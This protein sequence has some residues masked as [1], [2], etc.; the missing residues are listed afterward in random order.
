M[1]ELGGGSQWYDRW[2]AKSAALLYYWIVIAL[3]IFSPNSA[4]RFMELVEGHAYHTY[5]LYLRASET[6]LKNR[7]AP[8]IA[9]DYYRDGDLYMFDEFQSAQIPN[10]RRPKIDNLYDVFVAIRDDE[11]EH[12]KTM[13]SCQQ[14]DAQ[15]TLHSPHH[16][17]LA[18]PRSTELNFAD[19]TPETQSTITG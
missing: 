12:V 10:G 4:Y 14:T 1:E 7:P 6:E 15:A 16:L 18:T 8:A 17:T 5:D 9:L 2:L 13:R 19:T 11:M 3:Y